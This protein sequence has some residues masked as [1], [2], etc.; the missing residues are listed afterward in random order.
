MKITEADVTVTEESV[1]HMVQWRMGRPGSG[2]NTGN[3]RLVIDTDE[4]ISKRG[5]SEH[6]VN[7]ADLV[8]RRLHETLVGTNPL[9]KEDL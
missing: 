7:V 8:E 9:L 3:A 5:D 6:D 4:G 1:R 2:A